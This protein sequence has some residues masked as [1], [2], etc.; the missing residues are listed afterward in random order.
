MYA[1]FLKDTSAFNIHFFLNDIF[2]HVYIFKVLQP[3]IEPNSIMIDSLQNEKD[4]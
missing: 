2:I 4:S 1:Y 3:Q